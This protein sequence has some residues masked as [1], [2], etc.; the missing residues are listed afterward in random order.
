[1]LCRRDHADAFRVVERSSCARIA[2]LHTVGV[3][4]AVTP[5]RDP[6]QPTIPTSRPPLRSTG[7]LMSQA[8]SGVQSPYV[9]QPAV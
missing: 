9:A 5:A 7:N 6:T 4:R 8:T 2:P 3:G 1:M